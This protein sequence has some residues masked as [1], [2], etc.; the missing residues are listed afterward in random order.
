M[1]SWLPATI[2][3]WLMVGR[4]GCPHPN[5]VCMR[6]AGAQASQQARQWPLLSLLDVSSIILIYLSNHISPFFFFFLA[7]S[8][9]LTFLSNLTNWPG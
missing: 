9:S 1:A 7:A 3:D 4:M 8:Y 2:W 6:L 5:Q